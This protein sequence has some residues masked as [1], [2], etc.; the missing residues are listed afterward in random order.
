MSLKVLVSLGIFIG[1][2]V[3]GYIPTLWGAGLLSFSSLF[4][5]I[6]GGLIGIWIAYKI[7]QSLSPTL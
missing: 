7:S 4:G 1:S 5:S 3:G 2:T 6:V